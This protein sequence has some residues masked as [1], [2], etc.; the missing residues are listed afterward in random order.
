ML[1]SEVE[2]EEKEEES[3]VQESINVTPVR[4]GIF[5]QTR[6]AVEARLDSE[7]RQR[8]EVVLADRRD[9]GGEMIRNKR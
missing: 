7:S 6:K 1:P 5:R 2:E 9:G 4:S 8:R 3:P